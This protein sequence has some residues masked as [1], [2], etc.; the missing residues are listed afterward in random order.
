MLLLVVKVFA[1]LV[2]IYGGSLMGEMAVMHFESLPFECKDL[3][4][5]NEVYAS[6]VVEL[7]E[8]NIPMLLIC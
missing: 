2:H 6:H 1:N 3:K 8:K 4:H 5:V 7:Y